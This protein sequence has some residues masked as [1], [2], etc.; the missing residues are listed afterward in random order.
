M[1]GSSSISVGLTGS[2]IIWESGMGKDA[3]EEIPI[4]ELIE[5]AKESSLY[6]GV[7]PRFADR[8]KS[9]QDL[10]GKTIATKYPRITRE[11][12]LEEGIEVD[13]MEFAGSIEGLGDVYSYLV[14]LVDIIS[15]GETARANGIKILEM[16]YKVSLRMID[17][18]GKM[19]PL[20]LAIFED[21]RELIAVALQRKRMV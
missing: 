4:N 13:I 11:I 14:G 8:V 16:F 21:L 12:T 17:A 10:N 3:G 15:T 7:Y 1:D 20:E 18:P 19:T 5:N 2:D 6:I 9:I